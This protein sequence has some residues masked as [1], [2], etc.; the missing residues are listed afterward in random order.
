MSYSI[1]CRRW[2]LRTLMALLG[3]VIPYVA[4]AQA[5]PK[6]PIVRFQVEGNTLLSAEAVDSAV[7]PFIGP[8]KDFADVQHAVEALEEAYKQ[9]GY[10]S[11]SVLLPEQ[12]LERGE[13]QL[14]VIEARIKEVRIEGERH[15]DAE[16]VR[17]SLPGVVE[18]TI[19]RIDDISASL[20]VANENPFKKT[21]LQ[22]QPGER[23]EEINAR[24]K[25][26]DEEPS[27]IGLTLDNTG[28]SQTGQHRIGVSYQHGNLFNRDQI[29]TLQYQTSPEKL[30]DVHTYSAAYRV[31]LYDLG[32]VV[33]I[34]A[35]SSNVSTGF[36]PG[37]NLAIIGKGSVVG[38]RY[39][40]KLKR[41]GDYDHELMLGLDHKTFDTDIALGGAAINGSTR[42][43]PVSIAY[44][45][46]RSQEGRELSLNVS[47]TQ[48]LAGADEGLLGYFT[49]RPRAKERYSILRGGVSFSQ[50][51]AADW[52]ARAVVNGQWA[53]GALVAPEQFGIGGAN[54]V[55]GFLERE[56]SNDSG[57]QGN[58]ELYGPELCVKELSGHKCRLVGFFDWGSLR[59]NDALAGETV[60][61]NIASVGVGLRWAIGKDLAVQ[62]DYA[63]VL[64]GVPTRADGDW[65]FHGRIG[66]F[67]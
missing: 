59:R 23:G 57:L 37:A 67:F 5:I 60:R 65:R 2:A 34:Y 32:D 48:N 7:R 53:P 38:A 33:D 50:Q 52:Q 36:L 8:E 11:V 62:A 56:V 12:V 61:Q 31:P 14:R 54:S 47:L 9:T 45:G 66:W 39:T 17:N 46:Q 58:L 10:T 64:H 42:V 28:T 51:L 35:A 43:T 22:L 24:I 4:G 49:T 21:S 18:G 6:F 19:P 3:A 63:Y 20:R 25:I 27:K 1:P 29:L 41:V 13:V 40:L 26:S 15:F 30:S 44:N 55:R 16:N